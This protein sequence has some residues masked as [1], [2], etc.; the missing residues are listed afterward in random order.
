MSSRGTVVWCVGRWTSWYRGV[1]ATTII[2]VV[3]HGGCEK[4]CV[5]VSPA[6]VMLDVSQRL[7]CCVEVSPALAKL[8]VS[9]HLS[10]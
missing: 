6:L 7:S 1:V 2:G 9:Q 4:S 10:C 8:D 5:W 3:S